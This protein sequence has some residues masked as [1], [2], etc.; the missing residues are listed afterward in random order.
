MQFPVPQFLEVEDTVVGPLTVKQSIFL[1]AAGA[2]VFM[3]V[4]VLK[5][6]YAVFVSILALSAA[7]A[8]S[9]YRPN[10]RPLLVYIQNFILFG[11]KPKL[12][13]WKRDPEG[14]LVKRSIKRET[15]KDTRDME[16]KIVS[17]NRLQELA[18]MLDTR[19]DMEVEGEDGER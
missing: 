9:F 11:T 3:S 8:F 15:V 4:L 7:L 10:G 18:W 14:F 13:I 1:G 12:Y 6:V 5:P 17:R 2:I 19:Q 16:Y